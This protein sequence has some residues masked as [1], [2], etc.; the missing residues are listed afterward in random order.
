MSQE[1]YLSSYDEIYSVERSRDEENDHLRNLRIQLLQKYGMN[2]D[3]IVDLC[4]GTGDYIEQIPENSKRIIGIDA[5]DKFVDDARSRFADDPRIRIVKCDAR[6]ISVIL[7]ENVDFLFSFASLYIIPDVNVV[8]KEISKC[9]RN[10]GIAIL[11]FGNKRSISHLIGSW[12]ARMGVNAAP[13]S[14]DIR[15]LEQLLESENLLIVEQRSFQLFSYFGTPRQ[16]LL[17]RPF[18][19]TYLKQMLRIRIRGITI[20][21]RISSLKF[22]R[23]FAFRHFVIVKKAQPS[24]ASRELII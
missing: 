16:L 18:A 4:C 6:K 1:D 12:N 7:S 21:E 19:G 22:T 23:N 2:R 10:N 20:D 14:I 8:I 17:L 15:N 9:M 13:T 5:L 24:D 11:E 3:C